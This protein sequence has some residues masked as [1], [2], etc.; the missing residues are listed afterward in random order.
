MAAMLV[1][2]LGAAGARL[3]AF[4]LLAAIHPAVAV[5]VG[6]AAFAVLL[7]LALLV[8]AMLVALAVPAVILTLR[9]MLL[10]LGMAGVGLRRGRLSDGGS[11]DREGDRGS[12]DLHVILHRIRV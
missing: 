1:P 11:G 7:M 12:D 5:A 9:L 8:L 6:T 4:G 10:V 2:M 3:R